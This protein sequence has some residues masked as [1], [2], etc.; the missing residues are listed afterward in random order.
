MHASHFCQTLIASAQAAA[1]QAALRMGG[2]LADALPAFG[3]WSDSSRDLR[4]GSF[5]S[6]VDPA[7][8][9]ALITLA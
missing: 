4:Q 2:P 7:E 3:D 5:V 9:D 8:F 6:E 1:Q